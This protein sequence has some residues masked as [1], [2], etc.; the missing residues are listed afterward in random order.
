MKLPPYPKYKPSGI[1]WLGE[2]PEHWKVRKVTHG[3][4]TVGSGTTPTSDDSEYYDGDIPWVTTSELRESVIDRTIKTVTAAAIRDFPA[5]RIYPK[6]TLLFAMYGATVG[7]LGILGVDATL[8]QA[9]VAFARPFLFKTE[10]VYY[11]LQIRR[12]I[13]TAISAGG[14]QPNLSQDDLRRLR[15]PTPDVREQTVIADFLDR[16]TAKIDMLVAKTGMLIE[17][18]K[19]KRSALISRTVT[20]G[21]PPDAARQAGL[22]PH[23]KLKPSGINWLAEVPEHWEVKRLKDAG[24][25]IAGS[26]FPH[27]FQSV[28]DNEFPFYKV[29]DLVASSDGRV[30]RDAPNT[31]SLDTATFLRARLIPVHSLLYAKIGAA[32]LLNRRRITS[33]ACCID[34]N[35]TAY[36]PNTDIATI[37]WAFYW[38]S[39]VD[40]AEFVNPGAVPSISE[41]DQG[42][43]PFFVPPL[44]EQHAIAEFIDRETTIIDALVVNA[45]TAIE[46]LQEYRTALITAAVTGQVDVRNAAA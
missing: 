9:C 12:P 18:L 25:L 27:D 7:R 42:I 38:I 32:L 34:N 17:R 11:W 21:L 33:K 39:I 4:R 36:V 15:I 31:V 45:E 23:P 5:L 16:E 24:T 40:F 2:V 13:L 43:L 26:G 6:G 14:G 46:R 30:M 28:A 20:R 8:N 19:E 41:G 29:G 37:K 1:D 22:D 3:F 10:F 44:Q 35:L